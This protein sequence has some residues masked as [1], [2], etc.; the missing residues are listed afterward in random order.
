M[1]GISRSISPAC[2]TM[3]SKQP[4]VHIGLYREGGQYVE[5]VEK[6]YIY[7]IADEQPSTLGV[8]NFKQVLGYRSP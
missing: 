3:D 7:I 6:R 2:G 8:P 5:S 4:M 1:V